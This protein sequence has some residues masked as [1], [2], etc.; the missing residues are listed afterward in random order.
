[1]AKK[2]K[3]TV[4]ENEKQEI[5]DIKTSIEDVEPTEEKQNEEPVEIYG[6]LEGDEDEEE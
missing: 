3:S 4:I 2:I 1:M 5:V 6:T